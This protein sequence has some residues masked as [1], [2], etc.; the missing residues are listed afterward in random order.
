MQCSARDILNF[1]YPSAS[2]E[3]NSLTRDELKDC[4]SSFDQQ[5][6]STKGLAISMM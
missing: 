3:E 6:Y 1:P 2:N 4:V 5:V